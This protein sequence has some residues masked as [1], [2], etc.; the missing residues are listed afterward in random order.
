MARSP[1]VPACCVLAS[2]SP[3]RAAL[4][5]QLRPAVSASTGSCPS[6]HRRLPARLRAWDNARW[7]SRAVAAACPPPPAL[8]LGAG[9]PWS[10]LRG[11][12]EAAAPSAQRTGTRGS[13]NQVM[14][15]RPGACS[16]RC[17]AATGIP[18]SHDCPRPRGDIPKAPAVTDVVTT[19]G[20]HFYTMHDDDI[21]GLCRSGG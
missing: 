20:M 15:G 16:V 4:L 17:P 5:T 13:G 18:T 1:L 8:V 9:I 6:R 3:R 11:C 10:F 2:A 19:R 7:R 21:A 12:S 14:P